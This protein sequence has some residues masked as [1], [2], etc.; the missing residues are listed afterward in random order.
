MAEVLFM[1]F[2]WGKGVGDRSGRCRLKSF[3][4]WKSVVTATNSERS[5]ALLLL[6][7]IIWD[8]PFKGRR[9]HDLLKIDLTC[10]PVFYLR[11]ISRIFYTLFSRLIKKLRTISFLFRWKTLRTPERNSKFAFHRCNLDFIFEGA[12]IIRK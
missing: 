10:V 3:F 1:I 4:C 11:L 8:I 7:I 12:R 6:V 9:T 5:L 2:I